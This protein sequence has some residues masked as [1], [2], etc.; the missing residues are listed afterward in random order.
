MK[1]KTILLLQILCIFSSFAQE[2]DND[3]NPNLNVTRQGFGEQAFLNM[4]VG[5][6]NA[7][8]KTEGSAYYF[9][10]WNTEGLIYTKDN[11]RYKI[12]KVNINLYDNTLEA[13][14]DE[15]YVFTF[16]TNNLVKIVINKKVFRVLTLDN[17][18]NI[19]ELFF[20]NRLSI[21]RYNSVS[22]YKNSRNPMVNR[23][24]NEYINKEKYYLYDAGSLTKIKLSNKYFSK[25][26]QSETIS[27]EF[28][29]EFI[30]KN[31]LSLKK[32]ADLIKVLNFVSQ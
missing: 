6:V 4:G 15:G 11:K 27:Q 31:K 20:N 25:L 3:I 21:Y 5:F 17:E 10:N 32:E 8:A 26:F 23:K 24:D 22:Y 30:K 2:K 28:I 18:L 29:M 13:I 16:N 7:K 14:Y 19:F 1:K 9:D 12:K